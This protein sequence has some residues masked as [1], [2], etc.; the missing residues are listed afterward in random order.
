MEILKAE[1]P[2]ATSFTQKV[3]RLIQGRNIDY[4]RCFLSLC[5]DGYA[6][7]HKIIRPEEIELGKLLGQGVT[8]SVQLGIWN[9]MQVA[10]KLLNPDIVDVKE[11]RTEMA[12]MSILDHPSIIQCYGGYEKKHKKYM[13]VLKYYPCGNLSEVLHGRDQSTVS[14]FSIFKFY[15]LL[16]I[17]I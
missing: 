16:F 14:L 1:N 2:Y 5:S 8:G 11:F 9:G 6:R 4:L 10:V 7:F 12:V 13:I 17:T 15:F 3:K